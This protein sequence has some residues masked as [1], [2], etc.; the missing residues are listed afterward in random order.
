MARVSPSFIAAWCVGVAL[1][2]ASLTQAQPP[3]DHVVLVNN[4]LGM[5][6]MNHYHA[7][8]SVLPPY[9]TLQAQVVLRGDAITPPQIVT[10]Q[11][12]AR[13]FI[14]WQHLLR[15][16]DGFLG[17]RLRPFRRQPASQCR[18]DRKDPRRRLRRGRQ[19]LR[20]R[21]NPSDALHGRRATVEV[22][23]QVAQVILRDAG[24]TELARAYP[25]APVSTEMNCVSTGCHSSEDQI[26]NQHSTKGLR[27][28]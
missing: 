24:G 10:G 21:G 23:Y 26:L 18:S 8:I 16:Q 6:C 14:P 4:D 3:G 11:P 7:N 20:R 25:V 17:L 15:R 12:H 2:A 28:Q 5:H 27:P 19:P 1:A 22:P 13:V 9:N